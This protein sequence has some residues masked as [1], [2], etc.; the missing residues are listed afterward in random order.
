MARRRKRKARRRTG[1]GK[2]AWQSHFGAVARACFRE[3]PTSGK[4]F[5][6]CMKS[7]L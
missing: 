4:E 6:R 2:S 7:N 3:G 5:G 1:K